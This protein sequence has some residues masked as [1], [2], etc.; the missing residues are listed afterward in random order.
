MCSVIE[1][2]VI[3]KLTPL[4]IVLYVHTYITYVHTYV[5]FMK[6]L[7]LSYISTYFYYSHVN[8]F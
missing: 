8:L 1:C 4:G 6:N 5:F 7:Y 3:S 2:H